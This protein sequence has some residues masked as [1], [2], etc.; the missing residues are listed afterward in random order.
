MSN[1]SHGVPGKPNHPM[2]LGS[3]TN[4]ANFDPEGPRPFFPPVCLQSHWDP[5][6]IIQRTLPTDYVPQALGPRPWAKICLEYTTS[7][8][9]EPAPDV[10]DSTVLPL[11]ISSIMALDDPTISLLG[12]SVMALI[13]LTMI[14]LCK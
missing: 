2:E 5:T 6:K 9:N 12:K 3:L 11:G 14:A 4:V 1:Y 13:L 8:S 10:L 7:G